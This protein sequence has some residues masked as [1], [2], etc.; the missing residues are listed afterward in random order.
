VAIRPGF[1]ILRGDFRRFLNFFFG[2]TEI[3]NRLRAAQFQSLGFLNQRVKAGLPD[4]L[5]FDP[6]FWNPGMRKNFPEFGKNAD[7]YWKKFQCLRHEIFHKCLATKLLFN[8]SLIL[9]RFLFD[10]FSHVNRY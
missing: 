7:L 6:I 5:E 3:F 4:L 10:C 1:P 8:F 2:Q 9:I